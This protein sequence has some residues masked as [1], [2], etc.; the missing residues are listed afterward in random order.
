MQLKVGSTYR[1]GFGESVTIVEEVSHST[2][3]FRDSAGM[4][5]TKSGG[6]V[7]GQESGCNLVSEVVATYPTDAPESTIGGV[8]GRKDDSGKLDVTL[9]FDDLPHA[10]EAVT[11]VLQWAITKKLPKPYERGSWQGVEDFQRR[12]KGAQLRHE[13]NRSKALLGGCGV[14]PIDHET[15]LLELAHIAT[16]AMFRLEMAVRK[17]KGM[18]VPVGA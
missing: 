16:D 11:E 13:L 14:E 3:K 4:T 2:Y 9:F 7:D 6:Y 18:N 8:T 5:Y 10:I 15:E 17:G 1:N 12:Y